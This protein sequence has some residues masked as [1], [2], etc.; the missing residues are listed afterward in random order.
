MIE[1]KLI[2]SLVAIIV[3]L[4]GYIAFHRL[5]L[6]RDKS[7][8]FAEA[9]NDFRKYLLETTSHIP[10]ADKYWDNK[11]LESMPEINNNLELA[12]KKFKEHLLKK[13][14]TNFVKEW[15]ILKKQI[16]RQIPTA[17]SRQE[18]LYGGGT[19]IAK[20]QKIKFHERLNKLL[21]YANQT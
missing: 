4:F 1:N 2:I 5:A 7:S 18:I 12:V 14:K 21:Q 10:D 6:N 19:P 11:I 20:E 3:T 8:R 9:C 13:D 15:A 16:E 17:H